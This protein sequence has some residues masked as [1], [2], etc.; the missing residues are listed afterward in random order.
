MNEQ[1]SESGAGCTISYNY[2]AVPYPKLP[3]GQKCE[4]L[5]TSTFS[6]SKSLSGNV[7]ATRKDGTLVFQGKSHSISMKHPTNTFR[8]LPSCARKD[9]SVLLVAFQSRGLSSNINVAIGSGVADCTF[10][11]GLHVDLSRTR[12][13]GTP[14]RKTVM[15]RSDH[16]GYTIDLSTMTKQ[17]TSIL[18]ATRRPITSSLWAGPVCVCVS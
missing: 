10:A 9:R 7:A 5:L 4:N 15:P 2:K 14:T 8:K 1:S 12:G 11:L 3:R 17:T 6:L 13:G 18:R 16:T